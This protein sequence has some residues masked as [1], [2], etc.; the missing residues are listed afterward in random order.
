MGILMTSHQDPRV[1]ISVVTTDIPLVV[2]EE[3][4]DPTMEDFCR[5]CKKCAETCPS[6]AISFDD[7]AEI[8]GVKR[9]Q[10]SQEK[11]F[12]YWCQAGTDCD[13]CIAVCPY[14]HPDNFFHNVI[15][16]GIRKNFLFRKIAVRLDDFFYGKKPNAKGTL[17]K[18]K[19]S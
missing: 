2:S 1:R 11:C 19:I 5:I 12:T 15:R 17:E 4:A 13:K 14:S 3:K 7:M 9:W 10:I 18:I 8:G 6:N 16:Y